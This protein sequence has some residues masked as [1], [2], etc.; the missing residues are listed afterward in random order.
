MIKATLDGDIILYV[1]FHSEGGEINTKAKSHEEEYQPEEFAER[2]VLIG[3]H[4]QPVG[5]GG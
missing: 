2:C 4:A 1:G 5:C 3:N